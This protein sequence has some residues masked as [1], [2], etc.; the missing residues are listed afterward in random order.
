[1]LDQYIS[2]SIN[3]CKNQKSWQKSEIKNK[4]NIN[5]I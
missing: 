4:D 1:M 2:A 3:K 5:L